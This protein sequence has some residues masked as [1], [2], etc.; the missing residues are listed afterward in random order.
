MVR[1][2]ADHK[3]LQCRRVARLTVEGI[4]R[5][6]ARGAED[7]HVPT[8]RQVES[9]HML[10]A[11]RVLSLVAILFGLVTVVAGSRVLTG[12]DP[13]YIVFLP[14]LIFNT[15]MGV[16]YVGA[17]IL[18][19]RNPA[20]GRYPAGAIFLVNFLVLATVSYLFF[21]GNPVAVESVGAMALRTIVWLLLFL[22]L[23]RVCRRK[24]LAEGQ[25]T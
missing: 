2:I 6:Q 11:Y 17:G 15:A 3:V 25:H 14:L 1:E 23:V 9:R 12:G 7:G 21:A 13:G 4:Y 5:C 16:V 20:R 10:P 8:T 19:W 22:G 18:V 24:A